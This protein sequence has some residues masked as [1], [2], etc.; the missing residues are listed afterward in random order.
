M[1]PSGIET[2]TFNL[3]TQMRY[4]V[5]FCVVT[6]PN[7][8]VYLSVSI[9]DSIVTTVAS[10]YRKSLSLVTLCLA[11]DVCTYFRIDRQRDSCNTCVGPS[12]R[13]YDGTGDCVDF[14]QTAATHRRV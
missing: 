13:R 2:P 11:Y 5:F 6:I 8:Q 12:S 10:I 9:T 7:N 1:S 4:R 14:A 3:V